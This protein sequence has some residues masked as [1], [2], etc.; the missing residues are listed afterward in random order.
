MWVTHQ[1]NISALAGR[2]TSMGEVLLCRL[3]TPT[4]G[5]LVVLASLTL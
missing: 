1:V 5:Q 3:P 2:S 4:S